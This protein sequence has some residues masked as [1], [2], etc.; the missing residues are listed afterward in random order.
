MRNLN[1][2]TVLAFAVVLA[3]GA[4]SSFAFQLAADHRGPSAGAVCRGALREDTG[5]GAT[6][7][8]RSLRRAGRAGK[9][10]KGRWSDYAVGHRDQSLEK[11]SH[12]PR[13]QTR[14]PDR[15]SDAVPGRHSWQKVNY[16]L[17][18][19]AGLPA[20]LEADDA[21]HGCDRCGRRIIF[22]A[23]VV[24]AATM[25]PRVFTMGRRDRPQAPSRTVGRCRGS[26]PGARRR[27]RS[28]GAVGRHR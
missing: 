9:P 2:F 5:T 25:R 11:R 22:Y 4:C 14:G 6:T 27:R 26:V 3:S 23:S 12:P 10:H 24:S 16:R 7:G 13:N 20:Y 21:E 17:L 18:G 1:Q 15:S 19:P 28:P 8:Q